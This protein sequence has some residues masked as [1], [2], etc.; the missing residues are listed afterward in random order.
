VNKRL[1][2]WRTI[3]VGMAAPRLMDQSFLEDQ[4]ASRAFLMQACLDARQYLGLPPVVATG[5]SGSE[6]VD[7]PSDAS[8]ALG[9][10]EA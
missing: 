3:R 8:S 10:R 2:W 6:R 9:E 5:L 4:R 1:D 7:K